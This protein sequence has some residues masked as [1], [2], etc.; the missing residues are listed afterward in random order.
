MS[1]PEPNL[2]PPSEYLE[3]ERRSETRSEYIPRRMVAL[4]QSGRRRSLIAGNLFRELSSQLRGRACEAHASGLRL[5][6]SATEM[7]A[8]PDIVALCAKPQIEDEHMRRP[9]QSGGHRRGLSV[10][11]EFMTAER[12]SEH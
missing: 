6:V 9:S 12:S 4:P 7:Y 8:Y 10:S 5:K 3:L 11:T 1:S 2:L